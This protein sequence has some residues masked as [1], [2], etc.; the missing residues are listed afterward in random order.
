MAA[1]DVEF[2]DEFE[3]WW[4]SLSPEE[5][6]AVD[7]VVVMLE[8][9][10]PHLPFPYSTK[11]TSSRLGHL[12]ELRVQHRGVPYRVLYAFDPRRVA[13]LL[14]GGT[15]AGDDRWYEKYVPMADTLYDEHL[16]ELKAEGLIDGS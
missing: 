3:A 11:I 7:V 12:R 9:A 15:K 5:Q 13:L 4:D 1:W 6:D 8:Q 10:G 2:T 16:K 14:I